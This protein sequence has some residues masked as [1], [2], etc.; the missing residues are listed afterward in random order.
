MVSTYL[1]FDLVARNLRRSLT[2]VAQQTDVTRAASYYKENIG[3]V[4]TVDDFMKNDRLYRYAMKAYGLE[5]MTFAK[6]FMKK[7]LESDLTDSKSFANKLTD[8]RYQ[9]FAAA[10]SFNSATTAVAQTSY[11][12]DEMV[13][14][15]TATL[16]QQADAVGEDTRYYNAKIGS[17]AT[18]DQLLNNDR[19]RTYVF[20]AFGIDDGTWS[21]ATMKNILG[22]DPSDPGS[23]INTVW[24]PPLDDAIA[25]F[26]LAQAE[27]TDASSK[28]DDYTAQMAQP[29]A[30]LADL[31]AKIALEQGRVAKASSD[32]SGFNKTIIAIGHYFELASAFEFS[33]DGTLASGVAAQTDENRKITNEKFIAD[34]PRTSPAAALVEKA[35]FEQQASSARTVDE[36]FADDAFRM[37]KFIGVAFGVGTL[38]LSTLKSILTSDRDVNNASSFVNLAGSNKDAYTRLMNAFNFKQD[39]TLDAGVDAQSATQSSATIGRYM[40]AYNDA[41]EASEKLAKQMFKSGVYGITSIEKFVSTPSVYNFALEAVGLDPDSVSATTVKAALKSDLSDPKSYVYTLKDDR[42][43]Q[44]ARYFNFDSKGQLTTPLVAQDAAEV[45]NIAKDYVIAKT[46][47]ASAA[48]KAGLQEAAEK[49]ALYY[50][51]AIAGVDSVSELLADKKLVNF[52]LVAKGLDPKKVT[53]DYLRKIFSSDLSDAKSFA[54][55]ESD[56]RFAEIAA[57]FNFDKKGKVTRI[58]A[59]GPQSREQ[60]LETQNNYLQQSLESQQG[61]TNPGV[62]LALYF[63]RKAPEITSAY[64]ILADKALFEVFR[65]TYSLPDTMANAPIEKQAKIV[66][67]HLKL[68]DLGDPAKLGRVLSRFAVMY[69]L[70]NSQVSSPAL[71]ILNGAGTAMNQDTLMAIAQLGRRS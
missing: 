60:L 10:F 68:K 17:I 9:E 64:Q 28:I 40:T 34:Q 70:K 54:N 56:L 30:D 29:G 23:Y 41:D 55:K 2:L 48:E 3:K 5:D 51:N 38:P 6:A 12:T 24:G 53:N 4:K 67:K 18:V 11:Q 42:Y 16:Q 19:L 45:T 31:K 25:S 57:S 20:S 22:S 1:G 39:G 46:K 44:L 35:Y 37:A 7:V 58:A 47:F 33:T 63:Q 27:S 52:I 13:G 65:T 32:M 14:L 43:V 8:K 59:T 36:L 69:D 66:E 26:N 62:R 49:D 21:R 15:Y 50:K 71:T 61:N